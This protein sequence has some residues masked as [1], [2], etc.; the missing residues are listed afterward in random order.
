MKSRTQKTK[1]NTPTKKPN[2]DKHC[3]I[4][5]YLV[6][7]D[8][9]IATGWNFADGGGMPAV[10]LIAVGRLDE[11]GRLGET[12]GEDL[13]TDVV[14]TDAASNVPPRHLYC[15]RP[16]RQTIFHIIPVSLEYNARGA[17]SK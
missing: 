4:V 1:R 16:I 17:F 11:D 2:T 9:E 15:A 8:L 14:Q 13:A 3:L 7:E 10:A 12:F 5:T 6:I